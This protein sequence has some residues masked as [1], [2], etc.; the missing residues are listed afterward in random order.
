MAVRIKLN[1]KVGDRV[2]S[3]NVL[4]NSGYETDTPQLMIPIP[5]ARKLGLWPPEN[6]EEDTYDTA[7]GPL[8]VWIYRNAG[9]V[10]VAN[11]EKSK[12][13]LTDIVISPLADEAIMS[14]IL[15]GELEIAVEDFA[16]GLWRFRWEPPEKTRK[17]EKP[18]Y[19]K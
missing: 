19:W 6:A 12:E 3:V 1:I 9:I 5:L 14:D 2:E 16:E 4:I 13:V 17:T 8:K 7:G 18:Q 11:E 15:T 10:S